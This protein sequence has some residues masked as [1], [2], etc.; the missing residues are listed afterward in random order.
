[1]SSITEPLA[2]RAAGTR[3]TS[4]RNPHPRCV[5]CGPADVLGLGLQF[6]IRADGGVESEFHCSSVFEGYPH[7]LH[8]GVIAMLLDGAMTHCLFAR[9]HFAVTA[10]LEVRYRHPVETDRAA[11][12]RAWI[13]RSN[14]RLHVLAAELIQDGHARATASAKFI[15]RRSP[16]RGETRPGAPGPDSREPPGSERE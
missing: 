15:D 10:E 8:G 2:E 6:T 13:G 11:T 3:P 9:G 14:P 5:V 4:R 7:Q 16:P 1:M 12:V